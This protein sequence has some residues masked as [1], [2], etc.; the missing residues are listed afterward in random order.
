MGFTA[1]KEVGTSPKSLS[2]N[3]KVSK[4]KRHFDFSVG[5][6]VEVF[7]DGGSLVG[8]K[9][10]SRKSIVRVVPG[11]ELP[12]QRK[13]SLRKEKAPK[14]TYSDMLYLVEDYETTGRGDDSFGSTNNPHPQE[15][16]VES[17]KWFNAKVVSVRGGQ[18]MSHNLFSSGASG[19]VD[20]GVGG[21]SRTTVEKEV[22]PISSGLTDSAK[23]TSASIPE[24]DT[25]GAQTPAAVPDVGTMTQPASPS[26]DN[27]QST[28]TAITA[29]ATATAAP[30]PAPELTYDVQYQSSEIE[31]NVNL[32]NIRWPKYNCKEYVE[33]RWNEGQM[34]YRCVVLHINEPDKWG[35]VTYVVRY[36][37]D[38]EVEYDVH[39]VFMK[40][41]FR[42]TVGAKVRSCGNCPACL[43]ADCGDCKYCFDMRKFGGKGTLRQRCKMRRCTNKIVPKDWT[44][45]DSS[46]R[47]KST[48]KKSSPSETYRP[49]VAFPDVHD[50]VK[51]NYEDDGGWTFG[52]VVESKPEENL[53]DI[54]FED[55]DQRI[56]TV[57]DARGAFDKD[58]RMATFDEFAGNNKKFGVH[59]IEATKHVMMVKCFAC[60]KHRKIA[61]RDG[62]KIERGWVCGMSGLKDMVTGKLFD[63]KEGESADLEEIFGKEVM[64]NVKNAGDTRN[65]SNSPRR[66]TFQGIAMESAGVIDGIEMFDSNDDRNGG[67][68]DGMRLGSKSFEDM[69]GEDSTF[70]SAKHGGLGGY[71]LMRLAEAVPTEAR[72]ESKTKKRDLKRLEN[73]RELF[74]R[75]AKSAGG[76]A[77]VKRGLQHALFEEMDVEIT[78]FEEGEEDGK[79][80]RMDQYEQEGLGG[81]A[82][83]RSKGGSQDAEGQSN[84]ERRIQFLESMLQ[85]KERENA[86]LVKKLLRAEKR[87]AELES[88]K[89]EIGGQNEAT[90]SALPFSVTRAIKKAI[91]SDT[92]KDGGYMFM[93]FVYSALEGAPA[94]SDVLR[95]SLDKFD[96]DDSGDLKDLLRLIIGNGARNA[97]AGEVEVSKDTAGAADEKADKKASQKP[98]VSTKL[99]GP[100]EPVVQMTS[101]MFMM[102]SSPPKASPKEV[103][104]VGEAEAKQANEAKEV[105]EEIEGIEVVE[106]EKV[107]EE[108][109]EWKELQEKLERRSTN[110]GGGGGAKVFQDCV[111]GAAA[112]Q[113]AR[114]SSED[115]MEEDEL[116][117]M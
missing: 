75:A 42:S 54:L 22:A 16:E 82:V 84:M 1:L 80:R 13:M 60:A 110:E 40:R 99:D 74:I 71:E 66:Q 76:G 77:T 11:T 107:V 32:A 46:R 65:W 35:Q 83:K 87:V 5:S 47:K 73:S 14:N 93:K 86:S 92:R 53:V 96:P 15:D 43:A 70:S 45:N 6:Y 25:E 72:E 62:R 52:V 56:E 67:G 112:A 108:K 79:K 114:E 116:E 38:D 106:V 115:D 63:C 109:D 113:R 9:D 41:S 69:Y 111:G 27:Q 78:A 55:E 95:D 91:A 20:E 24:N 48:R 61:K 57:L 90:T 100:T 51:V 2:V 104:L 59:T 7:Y 18:E 98:E 101:S 39:P 58:F 8:E 34:F 28:V 44:N 12:E 29:T 23:Q 30:A 97:V 37:D 31:K 117:I 36:E 10:T 81:A 33:A 102:A 94:L 21:P 17:K 85:A 19:D 49:V 103:N 88:G 105:I 68:E 3:R 89:S 64:G 50:W 26:T 4:V